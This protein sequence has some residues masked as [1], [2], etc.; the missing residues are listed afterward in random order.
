MIVETAIRP[1]PGGEIHGDEE[2]I[3]S[4]EP[5]AQIA[6]LPVKDLKQ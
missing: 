5:G 4:N 1:R 3:E 6:A 2:R